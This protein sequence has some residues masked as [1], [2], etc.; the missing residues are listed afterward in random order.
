MFTSE[1]SVHI[2]LHIK[3]SVA[4]STKDLTHR[5]TLPVEATADIVSSPHQ[6][7]FS[8]R[9]YPS[10]AVEHPDPLRIDCGSLVH[11]SWGPPETKNWIEL[12]SL[13]EIDLAEPP[14][15]SQI[16]DTVWASILVP[17]SGPEQSAPANHWSVADIAGEAETRR[18]V[19]MKA[20]LNCIMTG[21]LDRF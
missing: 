14:F 11:R 3:N 7:M 18:A 17:M 20:N 8:Q 1:Y 5:D 21:G 12:V 19:V 16:H 6:S 10:G 4:T 9:T 2:D 15:V 13:Y